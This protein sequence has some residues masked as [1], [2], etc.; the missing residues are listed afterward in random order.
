[1]CTEGVATVASLVGIE[2]PIG[3]QLRS[4]VVE[5]SPPPRARRVW[6]KV[7]SCAR[8]SEREVTPTEKRP[9]CPLEVSSS[10][11]SVTRPPSS[12]KSM[13]SPKTE[14]LSVK[15]T[16]EIRVTDLWSTPRCSR[17]AR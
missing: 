12:Q 9:V 10:A 7:R 2:M 15:G 14:R 11:A 17:W 3:R 6:S 5:S 4:S 8:R 13:W 16:W 1:M